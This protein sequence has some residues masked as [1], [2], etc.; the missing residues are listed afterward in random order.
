MGRCDGFCRPEMSRE[1]YERR[2]DIAV[3]LLEGKIRLVT[4]QLERE[5]E[6]AAEELRF[7]EAAALR[8]RIAAIK[9][10]GKRQKVIAGVCADTDVWGLYLEAKCCFAVLHYEEGQ[11]TGKEAELF[12]ASALEEEGR[13]SRPCCCNTT[14]PGPRCPGRSSSPRPLRTR[15]CWSSCWGRRRGTG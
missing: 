4:A 9:V 13:S 7:E 11:L 5:M 8:D 15:R 1:E 6:A 10:L 2:V 12:A 14:A 3:Q